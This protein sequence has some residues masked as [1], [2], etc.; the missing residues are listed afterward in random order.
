MIDDFGHSRAEP[1][2]RTQGGFEALFV[3]RSDKQVRH[4]AGWVA[5]HAA[6]PR[7]RLLLPLCGCLVCVSAEWSCNTKAALTAC[8]L[9]PPPLLLLLLLLQDMAERTGAH[10]MELVW[11][12]SPAFGPES[13]LWVSLSPTGTYTPPNEQWILLDEHTQDN[14]P[15]SSKVRLRVEAPSL[16]YTQTQTV[17]LHVCLLRYH[18]SNIVTHHCKGQLCN[19]NTRV[20]KLTATHHL[21]R[22]AALCAVVGRRVRVVRFGGVR[23]DYDGSHAGQAAERGGVSPTVLQGS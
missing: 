20:S 23:R 16:S 2:L 3:A 4:D 21:T 14:V 18:A 22:R 11:R 5:G 6:L 15:Q 8:L 19:L 12:G 1:L 10:Q 13:D 9:P 17:V 7:L